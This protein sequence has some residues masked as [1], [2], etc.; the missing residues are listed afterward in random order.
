M[1]NAL[2]IDDYFEN[3]D[4][5]R[6]LALS[7]EN[8]RLN[9]HNDGATAGWRGQRTF[10]IRKVKNQ[11]CSCCNQ[12]I[13]SYSASDEIVIQQAQKILEVCDKHFNITNEYSDEMVISSFF[14]ITTEDTLQSY[15]DFWQ[16]RFHK[17]PLGPI[18][19]VVYLTPNAPPESG[20]SILD[21]ENNQF[22]NL[23]NKYN[24]LVAYDGSRIHAPSNVFG[25]SKET[26][27]LT[28]TF[29]IHNIGH[30]HY[31]N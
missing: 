29:F 16:D 1:V 17:D 2:I 14:H 21:G 3:P 4:E 15:P 26:G 24:R 5:I 19:G 8:Y 9:N 13:K 18:A 31:Y 11:Y 22:V 12:E 28:L 27:R 25:N 30:T 20:T 10:P 23:E 7:Y 6:E